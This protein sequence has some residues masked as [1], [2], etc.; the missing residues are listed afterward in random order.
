MTSWIEYSL[1]SLSD[2]VRDVIVLMTQYRN[3]WWK[4][5]DFSHNELHKKK[6]KPLTTYHF[7]LINKKSYTKINS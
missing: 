6:M 4:V 1:V 7:N 2:L 3:V 5:V